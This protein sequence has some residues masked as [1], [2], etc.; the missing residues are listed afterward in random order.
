MK[1][2]TYSTAQSI[3]T[4][5][6]GERTLQRSQKREKNL[7]QQA[8]EIPLPKWYNRLCNKSD[9]CLVP[10]P[11]EPRQPQICQR[12]LFAFKTQKHGLYY[13]G[14]CCSF[15]LSPFFARHS[16]SWRTYPFMSGC[17]VQT[18]MPCNIDKLDNGMSKE[19]NESLEEYLC[20]SRKK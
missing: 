12:Q 11:L 6:K 17:Y 8:K 19:T 16:L 15:F 1:T 14:C 13:T 3:Q 7:R 20:H 2:R 18:G 9:P 4:V 5:Q 10:V